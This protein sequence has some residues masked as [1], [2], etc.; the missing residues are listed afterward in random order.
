[1]T[2]SRRLTTGF[3]FDVLIQQFKYSHQLALAPWLAEHLLARLC[4]IPLP[5]AALVMPL[6]RARLRRRGV[7]Q[8]LEIAKP[9]CRALG[10]S[11]LPHACERIRDTESQTN[12]PWN[13]RAKNVRGAFACRENLAGRHIAIVDDVM[14]TGASVN[15]LAKTLKR[16]GAAR[17]SAWVIARTRPESFQPAVFDDL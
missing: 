1:M 8:S 12:L 2:A 10:L 3:R 14:T 5:Q 6:S 9:L 13:E 11:L 4:G 16:S 7:N 15:E 17:V